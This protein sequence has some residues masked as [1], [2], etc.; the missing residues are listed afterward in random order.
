MIEAVR[1]HEDSS[2]VRA[3]VTLASRPFVQA[4][5]NLVLFLVSWEFPR[6]TKYHK[7]RRFQQR[8]PFRLA[9]THSC[10][11]IAQRAGFHDAE[12]SGRREVATSALAR[13]ITFAQWNAYF[14]ENIKVK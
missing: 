1:I 5:G 2:F 3:L 7:C 9:S 11:K 8:H 13:Y 6:P 4:A 12:A 10:P 14:L